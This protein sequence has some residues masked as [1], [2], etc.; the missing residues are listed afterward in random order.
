MMRI[1]RAVLLCACIPSLARSQEIAR[2]S[3]VSDSF[4]LIGPSVVRHKSIGLR[5]M[6]RVLVRGVRLPN[7]NCRYS[8]HGPHVAG[9]SQWEEEVDPDT[10]T[11]IHGQGPQMQTVGV[12]TSTTKHRDTVVRNSGSIL[13]RSGVDTVD[14]QAVRRR[15]KKP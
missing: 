15:P 13:L 12:P 3:I 5:E 8:G 7:G 2:D 10:C 9:W 4:H 14:T 11:A 6:Q 1:L